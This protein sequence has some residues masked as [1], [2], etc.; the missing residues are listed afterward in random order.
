MAPDHL[1]AVGELAASLRARGLTPVLVGGMALVVL[2]SRRVT[3]DFDFVIAAPGEDLAEVVDLMYDRGLELVSRLT[4][5]GDVAATL[6][7]RRVAA[8]RL[9]ID[10]PPTAYFYRAASGLRV[11]LLFDFPIA[12]ATLS[13]RSTRV[14]IGSYALQVASESD[15]LELKKIAAANR[16]RP[17][18]AEDIAFLERRKKTRS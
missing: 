9:G 11:D 3:R 14:R 5:D 12:A 6:A 1:D 2:G 17:G 13:A 16:Q 8:A 15:L 7:N 10:A 4:K 18:D